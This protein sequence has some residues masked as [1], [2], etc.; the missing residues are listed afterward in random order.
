LLIVP[1]EGEG[2]SGLALLQNTLFQRPLP[3]QRLLEVLKNMEFLLWDKQAPVLMPVERLIL[4]IE[5]IP[6][7]VMALVVASSQY[8]RISMPSV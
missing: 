4:L 2:G 6:P 1:K 7:T 8:A 3:L 5:P